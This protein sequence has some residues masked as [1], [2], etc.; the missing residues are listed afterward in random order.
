MGRDA[1]NLERILEVEPGFLTEEHEHEHE[2]DDEIGSLS[3][4]AD[5]PM[6]PNRF[7][8]WIQDVTNA[9]VRK[10]CA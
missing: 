4:V 2:H 7:A 6:K 9:L 5:R 3:L 10:S 8:S 1:F